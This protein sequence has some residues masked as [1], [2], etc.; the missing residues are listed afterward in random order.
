MMRPSVEVGRAASQAFADGPGDRVYPVYF[1]ALPVD[2]EPDG[3]RRRGIDP[4]AIRHLAHEDQPPPSPRVFRLVEDLREVEA[5]ATI[6]DRYV[7]RIGVYVD[8]EV[9]GVSLLEP[10]VAH[11]VRDEF[12]RE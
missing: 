3:V 9:D 4:P 2:L 6:N 11:S 12:A 8:L 1:F 10:G 5:S 7:N